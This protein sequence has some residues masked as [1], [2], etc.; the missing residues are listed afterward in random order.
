METTILFIMELVQCLCEENE[1][2][3][4]EIRML[5]KSRLKLKLIWLFFNPRSGQKGIVSEGYLMLKKITLLCRRETCFH[6][7]C[8]HGLR[9][10]H[11]ITSIPNSSLVTFFAPLLLT[12][13]FSLFPFLFFGVFLL[14]DTSHSLSIP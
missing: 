10:F 5:W 3:K 2:W 12:M 13:L 4:R 6:Y 1:V 11:L 14:S 9:E 7:Q 8:F